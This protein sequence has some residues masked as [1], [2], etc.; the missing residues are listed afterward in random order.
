M[1]FKYFVN[2]QRSKASKGIVSFDTLLILV[3]QTYNN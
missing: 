2:L 3:T 1:L